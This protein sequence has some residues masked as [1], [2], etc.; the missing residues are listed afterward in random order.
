MCLNL[1]HTKK[2]TSRG[3]KYPNFTPKT[4][5]AERKVCRIEYLYGW[6]N[7]DSPTN[8]YD[9]MLKFIFG[10]NLSQKAPQKE[11]IV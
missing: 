10:S 9:I 7:I 6:P 2:C 4:G 1:I 11:R 8:G 5:H 3:E